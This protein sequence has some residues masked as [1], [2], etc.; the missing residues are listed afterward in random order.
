M[1]STF[2]NARED[3]NIVQLFYPATCALQGSLNSIF[4][5]ARDDLAYP[6]FDLNHI[7]KV[8]IYNFHKSHHRGSIR[9]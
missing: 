4:P 6:T 3:R 7:L 2:L 5:G 9:E 8:N 1:H